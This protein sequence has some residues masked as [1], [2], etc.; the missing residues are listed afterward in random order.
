MAIN[1]G[2]LRDRLT[3]Q[4]AERVQTAT[5]SE[6][7][8]ITI[9]KAWGRVVNYISRQS[10]AP[11]VEYQQDGYSNITHRVFLRAIPISLSKTRILWRGKILEVLYP[12]Q[13]P[14]NNDRFIIV[15]CRE[16]TNEY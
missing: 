5:G 2:R 15:E 3:I 1:P 11:Q 16:V 8:W 9:H 14:A 7:E 13:N 12:S 6:T 10:R 4:R